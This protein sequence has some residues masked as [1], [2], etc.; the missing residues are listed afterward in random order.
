MPV[1]ILTFFPCMSA[2]FVLISVCICFNCT[3]FSSI[4]PLWF[5]L[6]E[7]VYERI[8]V[9]TCDRVWFVT[10]FLFFYLII[11]YHLKGFRA[12]F[13]SQCAWFEGEMKARGKM[14]TSG[15]RGKWR[16]EGVYVGGGR[17]TSSSSLVLLALENCGYLSHLVVKTLLRVCA[18]VWRWGCTLGRRQRPLMICLHIACDVLT[19]PFLL[20]TSLVNDYSLRLSLLSSL[21]LSFSAS[22]D[23]REWEGD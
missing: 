21:T 10:L 3:D 13:A 4:S 8:P 23:G 16:K 1:C 7:S 19:T 14:R 15:L 12:N 20:A 11:L 17:P 6:P 2:L 9:F 22:T 5:F 18:C